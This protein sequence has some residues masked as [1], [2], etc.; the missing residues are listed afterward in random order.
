VYLSGGYPPIPLRRTVAAEAAPERSEGTPV[1]SP[2]TLFAGSVLGVAA[3][4][5]GVGLA[6]RLIRRRRE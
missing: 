5:A 4:Y 2:V 1:G 3:T 6:P